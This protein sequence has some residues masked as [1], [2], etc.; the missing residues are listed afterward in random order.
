MDVATKPENPVFSFLEKLFNLMI[1]N[2]LFLICSLPIITLGAAAAGMIQVVQDQIYH[3]EQPVLRRFFHGFSNNFK[4]ATAV[5]LMLL[6]FLTGMVCNYLLVSTYLHG[7]MAWACKLLIGSLTVVVVCMMSYLYPLMVR[8]R[9]SMRAHLNNSLILS[10]V[11]L[12]RTVIMGLINTLFFWIPFFSVQAFLG[13]MVLW[14]LF[15]FAFICYLDAQLLA[16]VFRQMEQKNTVD[17]MT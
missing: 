10:V 15:G 1:A 14:M 16:P 2:V 13:T 5:W 11:K 9:N 6:V 3:V 7:W 4:Q 17:F 8:Y 12:P